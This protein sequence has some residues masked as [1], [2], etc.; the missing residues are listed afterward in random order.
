MRTD[1]THVISAVRDLNRLEL[2]G[3]PVRACL[4]QLMVAAPQVVANLLDHSWGRRYA[5]SVDTWRMPACEARKLSWH[6]RTAAMGT[7][8]SK[9]CTP[10]RQRPGS[11]VPG[12]AASGEVLQVVLVQNYLAVTDE[13]GRR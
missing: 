5:A 1:S 2:A 12:A 8:C 9:R 6:W 7:R 4:E 3:E 11:G 10:L 13:Q